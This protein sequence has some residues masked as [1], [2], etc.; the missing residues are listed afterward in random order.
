MDFTPHPDISKVVDKTRLVRYQVNP[1]KNWGPGSRP[2]NASND[3]AMTGGASAG[4]IIQP[5]EVELEDLGLAV[6][7]NEYPTDPAV[8]E[9]AAEPDSDDH[10][11]KVDPAGGGG[12]GVKRQAE[13]GQEQPT[14]KKT[15]VQEDD[16]EMAQNA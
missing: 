12:S 6:D 15:R 7:P 8:A 14:S 11:A 13:Q 10:E 16:E 1:T 2:K 9:I 3:A 5:D 4:E